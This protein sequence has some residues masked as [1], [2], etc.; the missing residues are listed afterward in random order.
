MGRS[1]KRHLAKVLLGASIPFGERR[2]NEETAR[3]ELISPSIKT[4]SRLLSSVFSPGT[5]A[6]R[7]DRVHRMETPDGHLR[8]SKFVGLK[9][10][11]DAREVVREIEG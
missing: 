7:I 4:K 9:E 8:H 10:D 3:I 5:G 2:E 1:S 6:S 11:K